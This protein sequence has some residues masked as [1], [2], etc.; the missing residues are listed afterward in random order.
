MA[1]TPA[2]PT[3]PAA[4]DD[5]AAADKAAADTKAKAATK[6][7]DVKAEKAE[8]AEPQY[9]PLPPDAA[10]PLFY[11][12]HRIAK[13]G[14]PGNKWISMG[15]VDGLPVAMTPLTPEM[16]AE[17]KSGQYYHADESVLAV[18]PVAAPPAGP[19]VNVDVP[20]VSAMGQL[21]SCTMG[22]WQNEPTSYAYAWQRDGSAIPGV[23]GATYSM[24]TTDSGKDIGCIVTATNAAG[25]TAAPPS[26]TIEAP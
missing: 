10:W 11:N 7:A 21:A 6:V 18:P 23:I 15:R 22:N 17:I 5:K 20:Y 12:G 25:S 8:K 19:P 26:N 13:V 9:P 24:T 2:T 4:H 14:D 3:K 1:T 16:E